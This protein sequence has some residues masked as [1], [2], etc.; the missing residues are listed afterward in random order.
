MPPRV[1]SFDM[2][3]SQVSSKIFSRTAEWEGRRAQTSVRKK[4]EDFFMLHLRARKKNFFSHTPQSELSSA[5]NKLILL[6][7]FFPILMMNLS[8]KKKEVV[9]VVEKCCI[10][11]GLTDTLSQPMFLI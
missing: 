4:S 9:A 5:Q 1:L 2:F 10:Q 6:R 7:N 3:L 8:S 11:F